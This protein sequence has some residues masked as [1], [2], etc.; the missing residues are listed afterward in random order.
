MVSN[1][2]DLHHTWSTS[3]IIVEVLNEKGLRVN[4]VEY[5]GQT[6]DATQLEECQQDHLHINY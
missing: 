4:N 2:K 3:A 1:L 6:P 5:I